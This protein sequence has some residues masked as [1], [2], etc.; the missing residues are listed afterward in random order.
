[1]A[2]RTVVLSENIFKKY[3]TYYFSFLQYKSR[4]SFK[5]DIVAIFTCFLVLSASILLTVSARITLRS[6][7]SLD[8]LRLAF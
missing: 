3:S 8:P 7:A 4:V 2:D 6:A 1:M 5:I